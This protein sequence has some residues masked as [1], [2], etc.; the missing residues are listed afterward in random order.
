MSY[1]TVPLSLLATGLLFWL[2]F[3]Q[4][5]KIYIIIG[6]VRTASLPS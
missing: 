4:P 2:L 1:W 5:T 3:F 6:T